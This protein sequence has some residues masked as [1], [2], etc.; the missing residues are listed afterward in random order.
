M[1]NKGILSFDFVFQVVLR[2]WVGGGGEWYGGDKFGMFLGNV[3][4]KDLGIWEK[5]FL[6]L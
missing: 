6:F 5:V 1:Y 4:I 3:L 2:R